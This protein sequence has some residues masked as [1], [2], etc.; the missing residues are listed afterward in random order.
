MKSRLA[1]VMVVVGTFSVFGEEPDQGSPVGWRI[2]PNG[3]ALSDP[4]RLCLRRATMHAREHWTVAVR[5]GEL[6]IMEEPNQKP[7][8]VPEIAEAAAALG[9]PSSAISTVKEWQRGKLVGVDRGEWGGGLWWFDKGGARLELTR[10]NVRDMLV[11]DDGAL[12]FEGVGHLGLNYG[13]IKRVE[14]TNGRP[15]VRALGSLPAAPLAVTRSSSGDVVFVA[16]TGVW[17]RNRRGEVTQ[18]VKADYHHL[19]VNSVATTTKGDVYVGMA[20]SVARA[21]AQGDG[22]RHEWLVPDNCPSLVLLADDCRCIG[23]T[24]P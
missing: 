17:K 7:G 18:V 14:W 2:L 1:A 13:D 10:N 9:I 6:A 22:Y 20:V 4:D 3:G 5:N 23:A 11:D 16:T 15:R 21:L 12:V 8:D 19:R 24:P